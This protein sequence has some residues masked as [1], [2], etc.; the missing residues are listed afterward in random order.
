MGKAR[1]IGNTEVALLKNK[2]V[3]EDNHLRTY[4]SILYHQGV[5]YEINKVMFAK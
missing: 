1:R 2:K 3:R 5:T 4:F